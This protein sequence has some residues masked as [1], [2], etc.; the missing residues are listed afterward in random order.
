MNTP[1]LSLQTLQT[2]SQ[3]LLNNGSVQNTALPQ[4]SLTVES[5]NNLTL[6]NNSTAQQSVISTQIQPPQTLTAFSVQDSAFIPT[7]Q[8]STAQ[9]TALNAL[10][11]SASAFDA[12]VGTISLPPVTFTEPQ[13]LQTTIPPAPQNSILTTQNAAQ[14]S[15]I[16]V[17]QTP[18]NIPVLQFSIPAA[19]GFSTQSFALQ[20]PSEA[21]IVGSRIDLTPQA[22]PDRQALLNATQGN[23]TQ[24][25]P[26]L[27]FA[28]IAFPQTWPIM[29][30][31]QQSLTQLQSQQQQNATTQVAQGF[32]ASLPSP[33]NAVQFGAAVMFFVSAMRGGDAS[34]WLGRN[35]S[36]A[37]QMLD[38][39]SLLSRLPGE[40]L[41]ARGGDAAPTDWR[42]IN[43]PMFWEGDIQKVALHYKQDAGQGE[44]EQAQGLKGTRFLFDLSL[45][46]MG[47]VQVDGFFRPVSSDG[48]R[49]DI[50][51]RTEERFSGA[52]QAEMRRIYM[53]A[54]KPS[55]LGGELSFQDG[56]D[57]WV[58]IDA[59]DVSAVGVSA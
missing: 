7:V 54:L 44:N 18:V 11:P 28:N 23:T 14:I 16:V 49:M 48:A 20:F 6:P 32:Q 30:D 55:Q 59:Q 37:L 26:T 43:I 4:V 39:S 10:A 25:L 29:Q 41:S 56:L 42:G 53:D 21:L 40:A 13:A 5:L 12:R 51:L 24:V 35:A 57:A 50:V 19:E 36:E 3:I 15:A 34:Q 2:S 1:P 45:D 22:A 8:N 58:M 52:M 9:S 17:G 47:K 33:S 38:K 46:V 27:P 31:I